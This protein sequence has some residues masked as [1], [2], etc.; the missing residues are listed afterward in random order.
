MGEVI[1]LACSARV[2][3][4]AATMGGSI[5]LRIG[6]LSFVVGGAG[7]PVW[8]QTSPPTEAPTDREL[9]AAKAEFEEAQRL[10]IRENFDGAA[11]KFAAAYEKKPFAAFLFNAAVAYERSQRWELAIDYFQ[12]YID[13]NPEA[14]DRRDV[15][16]RLRGLQRVLSA[17]QAAGPAE[18][19]QPPA[20]PAEAQ[21]LPALETKGLVIIDSKPPGATIYIDDKKSGALGT[22]RWEGSLEPK[23][24][25]VIIEAK[26][27]KSESRQIN[28][29]ADKILEVYIALSE[30]HFLGWVEIASNVAGAEVFMDKKEIGAIGR[31]PYT[32]HVKPGK[33]TI[34]V[35]KAGYGSASQDIEVQPG[36]AT[37]HMVNLA[38]MEVGWIA[39]VGKRSRG[40]KLLVDGV[41]ACETPCQHEVAPGSHAV[42]VEHEGMENYEADVEVKQGMQTLLEVQFNPKP[43]RGRAWTTGVLSALFLG[44]GIYAGLQA[45]DREDGLAKDVAAGRLIDNNDPRVGE[46]KLWAIG[47]NVAFGLSAIT[48]LMSLY[49]FIR[50]G[51]PSTAEV[52]DKSVAITPMALPGGGGLFASGGF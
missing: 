15:E 18:P 47:A 43:P 25:K 12:R 10:F 35:E 27:F 31:T 37:M 6:T 46:G 20:A 24:V 49:N 45:K 26:G 14:T 38:K 5:L 44:G 48:G 2:T 39:V 41:P 19:G 28:P 40:G 33:H 32:G 23:P 4:A 13:R 50:S 9:Q 16:L 3:Q 42:I 8:A 22:T 34:W 51:P 7:T 11:A 21:L 36:T 52:E 29:R 1:A 30:E 17:S